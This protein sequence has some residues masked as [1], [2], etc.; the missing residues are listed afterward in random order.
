MTSLPAIA[1][2]LALATCGGAAADGI[3][4]T[5]TVSLLGAYYFGYEEGYDVDGPFAPPSYDVVPKEDLAHDPGDP[6]RDLGYSWGTAGL[7][8]TVAHSMRWPFLVA[9]GPLFEGNHLTLTLSCDLTP[10]SLTAGAKVAVTPAAVAEIA[11]GASAG[12]GWPLGISNGLGR[13]LPGIEHDAVEKEP[14]SGLV[15][16]AWLG[17]TLQF[18]LAA[19]W[20][21][22]WH[23]FVMATGPKLAY[24]TFTNAGEDTA[25][26]W[27]AD[28]GENFNGWRLATTTILGYRMPLRVDTVG[29]MLN[30]VQNLGRNRDRSPMGEDGWGSDFVRVS[31]SP[32][33]AMALSGPLRLTVLLQMQTE[34]DY[35]DETIGNR[36]FELRQYDGW[37]LYARR[38]VAVLDWRL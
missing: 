21:G 25:W 11:A 26:E 2:A 17:A 6:G 13:N 4:R 35:T 8:A 37:Y 9:A 32:L 23:H 16:S 1:L 31:I 18:D 34:P 28:H 24:W 5:T 30:T 36:Y 10:V 27:E 14:F 19:V 22:D 33:A 29:V 3:E 12:T 15:I 20:P 7:K 38:L